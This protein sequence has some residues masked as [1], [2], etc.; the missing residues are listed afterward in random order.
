MNYLLFNKWHTSIQD[1]GKLFS[2]WSHRCST[3]LNEMDSS[4][5]NGKINCKFACSVPPYSC[6]YVDERRWFLCSSR[7]VESALSIWNINFQKTSDAK[8]Y[9]CPI[10]HI[11]LCMRVCM[12]IC[13]IFLCVARKSAEI[14]SIKIGHSSL[15]K[16]N[17]SRLVYYSR[18]YVWCKDTFSLK[19]R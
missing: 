5:V 19:T 8:I 13:G 7:Y 17:C 1:D 15:R 3:Y 18:S 6:T 11:G 16:E 9:M 12:H 2:R 14:L 10:I 4:I